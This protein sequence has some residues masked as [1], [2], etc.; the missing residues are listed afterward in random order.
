VQFIVLML[1]AAHLPVLQD[2]RRPL[3]LAAECG[4]LEIVMALLS[5]KA[6]VDATDEVRLHG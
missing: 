4:N 3:H 6:T 1:G 2:G 5:A